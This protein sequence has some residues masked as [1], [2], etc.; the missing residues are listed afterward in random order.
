[1]KKFIYILLFLLLGG[2]GN[3]QNKKE[4]ITLEDV[5]NVFRIMQ[6][7]GLVTE[8]EFLYSYFFISEDQS[9][10]EKLNKELTKLNFSPITIEKDEVDDNWWLNASRVEK[11]DA[12]SLHHLNKSFYEIAHKYSVDYNGFNSTQKFHSKQICISF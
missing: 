12:N 3:S 5:Q 11:H 7:N 8:S 9:K 6:A 1:M 2:I 4:M 10:L